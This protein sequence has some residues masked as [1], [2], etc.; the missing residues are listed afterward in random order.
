VLCP[1]EKENEATSA[2]ADYAGL[3]E[4][5]T[6]IEGGWAD[7]DVVIATP[8]VMPKIAKLGKILGPRN[9]MP[10]PKSGTVTVKL[11]ASVIYT[12]PYFANFACNSSISAFFSVMFMTLKY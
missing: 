1:A 8:S 3:A 4:Y 9:L 12:F 6:K 5:V 11:L 10:N 2:G 7:I